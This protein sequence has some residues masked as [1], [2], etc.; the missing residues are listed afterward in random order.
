[1]K[2][3]TAY[4]DTNKKVVLAAEKLRVKG[5]RGEISVLGP[6]NEGIFNEI[7]NQSE[8]RNQNDSLDTTSY[9]VNSGL[10]GGSIGLAS[11]MVPRFG[12]MLASGP[13]AGSIGGALDGQLT[14][15][16]TKWGISEGEG[17]AL[18]NVIEAG[19]TT[20]LIKG[21]EDDEEFIK[22]VLKENGGKFIRNLGG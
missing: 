22:D 2:A 15:T 1:M 5:F 21:K 19:N 10:L 11:T 3:I 6:N 16:L 7:E 9:G 14:G 8:R 20:I 13:I 18:E 12:P 17:K 4:F